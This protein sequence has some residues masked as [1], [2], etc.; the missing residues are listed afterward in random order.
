MICL[1]LFDII[2]TVVFEFNVS[3]SLFIF[4]INRALIRLRPNPLNG[5]LGLDKFEAGQALMSYV[6]CL[7]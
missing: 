2:Y 3:K 6:T 5:R 4:S 1:F 7:A